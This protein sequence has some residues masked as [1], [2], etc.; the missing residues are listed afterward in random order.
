M[1]STGMLESLEYLKQKDSAELLDRYAT[2]ALQGMVG[3][4]TVNVDRVVCNAFNIAE[5]CLAE[6]EKRLGK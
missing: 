6:R 3:G 1:S 5:A 4:S 2:A